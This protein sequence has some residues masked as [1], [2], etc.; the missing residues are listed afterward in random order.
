MLPADVDADLHQFTA[1]PHGAVDTG[2]QRGRHDL[3]TE[4]GRSVAV[5]VPAGLAIADRLQHGRDTTG[6]REIPARDPRK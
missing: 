1:K 3:A 2:G 4:R 6:C 5:P